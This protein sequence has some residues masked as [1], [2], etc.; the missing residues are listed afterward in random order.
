MIDANNLTQLVPIVGDEFIRIAIATPTMDALIFK[1]FKV[2]SITDRMMISDSGK[3]SYIMHF[4]SPELFIDTLSP[5]Y[6]TYSGKISTVVQNIYEKYVSTSRYGGEEPTSLVILGPTDNEVKFTS[7]GWR[8]FHCINWLA[9]RSIPEGYKNPGYL[10]YESNKAYYFANVEALIDVAIQSNSIYQ[11]YTYQANKT[12]GGDPNDQAY[13]KNVDRD[14]G[15]V[16]EM[17]VVQNFN[18]L[19]N[20]QNGYL[21]NR[22]ITLDMLTKDYNIYD[23]DHVSG[24]EDYKHLENIGGISSAD[25][26]PFSK[27]AL[28]S[29]AGMVNFYPQ[30]KYLYNGFKDNVAD[31]IKQTMPRR[32]STMAELSNFKIEITVPGR[33]DIEVGAVVGYLYPSASPRDE[34][35]KTK[36]NSDEL[37]TGYY[38]V[39]AIRHKITLQKHMMILELVKDSLKRRPE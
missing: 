2:Y 10:F 27:N 17:T 12:T 3:Q 37:Y 1:T 33:T 28:H 30:H 15:K 5:I 11:W 34:T 18:G 31:K 4:C 9:A 38:L 36:F 22:L 35:D 20:S 23:Y 21:A 7:P 26:A 39:T 24:Y 19:R 13:V 32:I 8:P 14:Y 16:E 25:C 6:K 29:P